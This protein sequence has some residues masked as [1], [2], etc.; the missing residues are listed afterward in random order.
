MSDFVPRTTSVGQRTSPRICHMSTPSFGRSPVARVLRNWSRKWAL[1]LERETAGERTQVRLVA[2]ARRARLLGSLRD[3]EVR[4]RGIDALERVGNARDRFR[5]ALETCRGVL[6]RVVDQHE[7]AHACGLLRG[8]IRAARPPI[9]WPT[10]DRVVE[11]AILHDRS[12]SAA[13]DGTE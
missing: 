8:E 11:A 2:L 1:P 10:T 6:G 9:E 7:P 5:G 3:A 13:I 4:H 12:E